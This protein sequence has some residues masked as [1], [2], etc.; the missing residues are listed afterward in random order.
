VTD[1]ELYDIAQDSAFFVQTDAVYRIDHTGDDGFSC[2]DE[3]THEECF[4]EFAEINPEKD[5]FF[6]LQKVAL[7]A[8][9]QAVIDRVLDQIRRDVEDQDYTAIEELIKDLPIERLTGYL[10]EGL[11]ND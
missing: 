6:R 4:V 9:N 7:N 8:P 10:P 5:Y 2:H 11:T 1:D 3:I